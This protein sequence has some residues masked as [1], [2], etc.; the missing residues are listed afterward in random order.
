M[1]GAESGSFFVRGLLGIAN[2]GG[3][4]GECDIDDAPLLLARRCAELVTSDCLPGTDVVLSLALGHAARADAREAELVV[5]GI[6][7]VLERSRPWCPPAKQKVAA[8]VGV[9][10]DVARQTESTGVNRPHYAPTL[11]VGP[12]QRLLEAATQER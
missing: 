11:R 10:A 2:S 9:D 4:D 12:G 1:A 6:L 7:E 5:R 3:S 8:I